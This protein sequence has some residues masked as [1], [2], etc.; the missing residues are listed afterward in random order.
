VSGLHG[1][2]GYLAVIAA[3]VVAMLA[4]LTSVTLE[5]R[6][7]HTLALLTDVL[8]IVAGLLVFGALFIGGLLIITG[9]RPDAAPHVVLAIAALAA[10]PVAAAVGLWSEQGTGRSRRRYRWLAGG[11]MVTAALGLALAA[12]G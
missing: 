2:L 12:T 4:A 1:S 8:A 7:G 10:M 9:L 11:A 3:V 5:R 6:A